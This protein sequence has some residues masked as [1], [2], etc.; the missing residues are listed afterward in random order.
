V[1]ASTG[2]VVDLTNP[3]SPLPAGRFAF[4]GCVLAVRS[5]TR[6]MMLCPN[7]EPRGPI[8][9]M[10]DPTTFTSV[11][12]VTLPDSAALA[13]W[14]DMAYIGGDAVALLPADLPLQIMHAPLIGSP[15]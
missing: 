3:D 11:G 7:P 14:I 15:P 9:R 2:D 5:A 8:L 6:I 1:Y 13:S 12:S 10:L 4:G